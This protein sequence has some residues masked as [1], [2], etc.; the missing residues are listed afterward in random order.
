MNTAH[1]AQ[2]G[3]PVRGLLGERKRGEGG[4]RKRRGKQREREE[5][6]PYLYGEWHIAD[7]G[8]NMVP[9]VLATGLQIAL[10]PM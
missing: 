5:Q 8:G 9:V 7:K 6:S 4:G 10:S 1:W 2:I 3:A